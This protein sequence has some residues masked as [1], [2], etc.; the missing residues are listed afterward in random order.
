MLVALLWRAIPQRPVG[1]LEQLSRAQRGAI[2]AATL[3]HAAKRVFVA[4][5]AHGIRCRPLE[6]THLLAW[7]SCK[8]WPYSAASR[9]TVGPAARYIC[10]TVGATAT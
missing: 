9:P 5:A 8:R 1:L 10:G 4:A 7:I 2:S 6:G 3:A